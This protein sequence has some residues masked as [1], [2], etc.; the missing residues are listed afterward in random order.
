MRVYVVN[1]RFIVENIK[2][3]VLHLVYHSKLILDCMPIKLRSAG[4]GLKSMEG[5]VGEKVGCKSCWGN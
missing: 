2:R 4:C 3:V 5:N 1:V